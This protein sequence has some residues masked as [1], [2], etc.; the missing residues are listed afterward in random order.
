MLSPGPGGIATREFASEFPNLNA[1]SNSG[2]RV[3]SGGN[4][5]GSGIPSQGF[6]SELDKRSVRTYSSAIG[7]RVRKKDELTR[8]TAPSYSL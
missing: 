7:S 5:N 4:T 3:V 2:Q 1:G 8:N 6:M